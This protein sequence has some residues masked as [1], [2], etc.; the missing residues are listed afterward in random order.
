MARKYRTRAYESGRRP[1]LNCVV[2]DGVFLHCSAMG[3]GC[4]SADA[5]ERAMEMDERNENRQ[6][7]TRSCVV[8]S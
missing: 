8:A 1:G 4:S 5:A 7:S 2:D 6:Q 3:K